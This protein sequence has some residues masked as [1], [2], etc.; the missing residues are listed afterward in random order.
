MH[1]LGLANG[2][3]GGNS[4]ILLKAALRA[5]KASNAETT[6]SWIHIPSLSYPP[7]AGPLEHAPDVSMGT[8]LGNNNHG[9]AS[10][11]SSSSTS[12][13]DTSIPDD[14]STLYES[15]MRADALLFSSAVYSH[16][17]AGSLKAALDKILG[18]YTDPAFA[19]RIL[20]GQARGDAK[21]MKMHVDARVLRPRVAG[22]LVVGGSTTPDQFTMALPTLHLFAYGLHVKVVD[23]HV[24][25]SCA[26]PG[27]VVHAQEGGVLRRAEEMGRRVASQMGRGFDEAKYLGPVVEGGCPHCHLAKYDFFGGSEM[28]MGC[29]VCGNTGRFV[30]GDGKV[31]VQWDEDSDYCCITWRGKQKH[32]DDIFKNGSAEWKGLQG[33]KEKLQEWRELD[34]GR[35]Q[36]PSEQQAKL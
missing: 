28:K 30:V 26:N 16:Q 18:P 3:I 20:E 10:P 1:I 2:S 27:A 23:Q 35:V 19:S 14:R 9:A 13:H 24:V 8:N 6:T 29:V 7:N 36:L 12:S 4:T 34:M 32:I 31:K 11:S 5:A 25:M 17:P 21:F 33:S 22:F 15:I